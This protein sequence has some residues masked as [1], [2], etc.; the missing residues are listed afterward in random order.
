MDIALDL[1]STVRENTT[2]RKLRLRWLNVLKDNTSVQELYL[3]GNDLDVHDTVILATMIRE[4][5][6]LRVLHIKSNPIG[7]EGLQ[8]I[9][10]AMHFNRTIQ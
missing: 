2:I 3:E 6:I 10:D 5:D 9:A 7:A 1:A 4:N 8:Q